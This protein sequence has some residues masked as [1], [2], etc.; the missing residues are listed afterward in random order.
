MRTIK[1]LLITFLLA[2][3]FAA[4]FAF[5]SSAISTSH[6][7][8]DVADFTMNQGIINKSRS[9]FYPDD[10]FTRGEFAY[11]LAKIGGGPISGEAYT[12]FSD[13]PSNHKYAAPIKWCK[14][15]GMIY[16]NT[17]GTYNPNGA[18]IREHACAFI[19]RYCNNR[20]VPLTPYERDMVTFADQS[21][22]TA[23]MLPGITALYRV[24]MISGDAGYFRPKANIT[25]AEA[26]TM[27][28]NLDCREYNNDSTIVV[29]VKDENGT[30]VP[31][32]AVYVVPS[33]SGASHGL[34]TRTCK[35]GG[36]GKRNCAV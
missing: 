17:D 2:C 21:S 11:A 10:N 27:L 5:T 34:C 3:L 16:G 1:K 8:I 25:V 20:S 35:G 19:Y 13:I 30:A 28:A 33:S 23:N 24:N 36:T 29:Y 31:N 4:V 7:A 12:G 22:I 6:W 32:A 26:A 15:R 9:T 14:D 18:V